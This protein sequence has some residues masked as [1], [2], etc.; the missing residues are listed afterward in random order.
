L[1]LP[2]NFLFFGAFEE[3]MAGFFSALGREGDAFTFGCNQNSWV[4]PRVGGTEELFFWGGGLRY[5]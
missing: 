2:L 4:S 5:S 3:K 1:P